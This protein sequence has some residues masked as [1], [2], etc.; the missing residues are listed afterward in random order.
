M[1]AEIFKY[2]FAQLNNEPIDEEPLPS[3]TF[4]DFVQLEQ[5]ALKS[6]ECRDFWNEKLKDFTPVRLP[7]RSNGHANGGEAKKH[8]FIGLVFGSD[9]YEGLKSLAQLAAVPFKTVLLTAHMKVLSMTCAQSDVMT[10]LATNGRPEETGGDRV[11]G[12]FINMVPFRLQISDGSWFELI[13]ET[14][15]GEREI[16]P[17]RRYPLAAMQKNYNTQRLLE[18]AFNFVHFHSLESSVR[19]GNVELISSGTKDMAET[20]FT[21]NTGFTIGITSLTKP[22]L[23]IGLEYDASELSEEQIKSIVDCYVKALK[24]MARDP[25]ASH[26]Q[27]TAS[28]LLTEQEQFLLAQ[29]TQIEELAGTFAF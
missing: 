3:F 9:L 23:E 18:T 4:R 6:G 28:H 8:G 19:S 11:R 26:T 1:F 21:M 24:A 12:L 10:A 29:S 5:E 27:W 22:R 17:Y 14:F 15:A 16:L 13:K 25:Y 20:S 2:Y 7:R